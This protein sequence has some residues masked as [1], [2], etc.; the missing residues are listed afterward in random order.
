MPTPVAINIY[1]LNDLNEY[2]YPF[3]VG[4]FHSGL[5]VHGREYSFGGH[6]HATSGIFETAP[7]EAPPPARFRCTAIV[8]YTER[9]PAEVAAAVAEAEA[10]AG[11]EDGSRWIS[12]WATAGPTGRGGWLDVNP[13]GV[14]TEREVQTTSTGERCYRMMLVRNNT[15]V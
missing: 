7:R 12:A 2:T 6:D 11:H 4:I 13:L 14:P 9:S 1:D 8:G 5:E 10:G 15:P 3:G